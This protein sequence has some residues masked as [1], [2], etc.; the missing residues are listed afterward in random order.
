MGS[1]FGVPVLLSGSL[2]CSSPP[3]AETPRDRTPP[4]LSA[5]VI[6]PVV[7][8][9]SY[10]D[11]PPQPFLAFHASSNGG[12]LTFKADEVELF[13]PDGELVLTMHGSM[14]PKTPSF[15]F[16]Y[17]D[18]T[19]FT[20]SDLA[21]DV[22]AACQ[23][24]NYRVSVW[25]SHCDCEVVVEGPISIACWP[26]VRASDTLADMGFEAP[27]GKPCAMTRVNL[28]G[29]NTY[30]E[31]RY[32]YDA[33]GRLR[34]IDIYW[35][36]DTDPVFHER[37]AF[38][39]EP[40]GYLSE[41]QTIS[42]LNGLMTSRKRYAYGEDGLLSTTELD[43]H[44]GW[45]DGGIDTTQRFSLSVSPWVVDN[46]YLY[47]GESSQRTYR[48][49]SGAN[50]VT[51]DNGGRVLLGAPLESPNQMFAL[52][53]EVDTV[54]FLEVGD[55]VYHYDA[56]GRLIYATRLGTQERDDYIFDCP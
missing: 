22:T 9:G 20:P 40:S 45:M 35:D 53:E 16:G 5:Q 31:H 47:S 37:V 4:L 8:N 24:A 27:E 46:G 41:R 56:D 3:E 38:V 1:L 51:S 23:A 12:P 28:L 52:P 55:G 44:S 15:S 42:P 7:V 54:K 49:D 26:D 48:Y 13:G 29:D 18:V 10:P 21:K 2:A 19:Y 30:D 6:G 43:G 36:V 39:W 25:T 32:R 11:E 17:A 34:F 33:E 14:E 50:T